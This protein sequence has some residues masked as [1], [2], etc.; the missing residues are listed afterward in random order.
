[1]VP[2]GPRCAAARA[3]NTTVDDL[4]VSVSATPNRPGINGFTVHAASTRRPPPA[5]NDG[6]TLRLGGSGESVTIPLREIEPG[7]YFG[8]GRLGP[9][10][11]VKIT[12]AIRRAGH[13]LTVTMPWRLSPKAAP[14]EVR[15]QEHHLAPYVNAIALCVLLLALGAGAQRIL[16]HRRR[17]PSGTPSPAPAEILEDVR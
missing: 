1:M 5:P 17:R 13:R 9:A 6:V 11:P 16:V 2:A 7:R 12:A 14:P 8:T 15:P 4:V 3:Y 10:G